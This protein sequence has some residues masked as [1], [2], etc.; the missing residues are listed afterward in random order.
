MCQRNET[1]MEYSRRHS[2]EGFFLAE[3]SNS[4]NAEVPHLSSQLFLTRFLKEILF[5]SLIGA[6]ALCLVFAC[7]RNRTA[8]GI[9][10]RMVREHL[11]LFCCLQAQRFNFYHSNGPSW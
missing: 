10:G 1:R 7:S 6:G 3:G 8:V 11:G 2:V 4:L 5:P 9:E